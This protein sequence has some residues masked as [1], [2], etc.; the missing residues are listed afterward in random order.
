[1]LRKFGCSFFLNEIQAKLY[2]FQRQQKDSIHDGSVKYLILINTGM[3][4]GIYV[5]CR[6][7]GQ[8]GKILIMLLISAFL[9]KYI[10]SKDKRQTR[11]WEEM[12]TNMYQIKNLY[13]KYTENC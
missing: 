1:M 5:Y 10:P 13:L 4:T 12:F 7:Y 3:F 8:R 9:L 6:Q 11:D 2:S